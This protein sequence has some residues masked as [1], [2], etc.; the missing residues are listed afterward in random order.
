MIV[1][2]RNLHESELKGYSVPGGSVMAAGGQDNDG[3]HQASLT[4]DDASFTSLTLR[5]S[6]LTNPSSIM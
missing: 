3:T 1:C 6:K 4:Q 2:C 5:V